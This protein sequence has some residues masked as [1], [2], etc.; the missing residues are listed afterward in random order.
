MSKQDFAKHANDL[1]ATR[2]SQGSRPVAS[3][4]LPMLNGKVYV[5]WDAKMIQ[6]AMRHKDLTFDILSLEFAQRVFGISDLGMEKF[7][8]PDH[9]VET[10]IVPQVMHAIKG[11][12]QGQS[13]YRMNVKALKY[14]AVRLNSI[15]EEGWKMPNL[16]LGLRDFMTMATSEGLYGSDNPVRKDPS[17]IDAIW[18]VQSTL[19]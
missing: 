12:M 13:L 1:L 8:G 10:S 14:I 18:Y 6:S 16:Y 19:V 4:T 7:W 3:A 5:I 9:D 17:L 11:A 2:K 15:G